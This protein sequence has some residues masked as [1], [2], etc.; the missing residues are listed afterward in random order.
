MPSI[1]FDPS[2]YPTVPISILAMPIV[3]QRE[4]CQL[5][6]PSHLSIVVLVVLVVSGTMPV[7]SQDSPQPIVTSLSSPSCDVGGDGSLYN[8]SIAST[9]FVTVAGLNFCSWASSQSPLGVCRLTVGNYS[10]SAVITQNSTLPDRSPLVFRLVSTLFSSLSWWSVNFTPLRR[11]VYPVMLAW[12]NVSY[13][14]TN[15]TALGI[16][17]L[18]SPAVMGLSGCGVDKTDPITGVTNTSGCINNGQFNVTAITSTPLNLTTIYMVCLYRTAS[19]AGPIA[20]IG[21]LPTTPFSF[22]F[23]L[24]FIPWSSFTTPSLFVI[25]DAPDAV[26]LLLAHSPQ[27]HL[28]YAPLVTPFFSSLVSGNCMPDVTMPISPGSTTSNSTALTACGIGA[29]YTVVGSG[30]EPGY[31]ITAGLVPQTC[32]YINSTAYRCSLLPSE[33][34]LGS[35]VPLHITVQRRNEEFFTTGLSVA[36]IGPLAVTCVTGCAQKANCSTQGCSPGDVV[37]VGGTGWARTL[38]CTAFSL[39]G[40]SSPL[41]GCVDYSTRL[42]RVV[43][44][45][46]YTLRYSPDQPYSLTMFLD[47]QSY[48]ADN[49]LS[50]DYPPNPV[51]WSVSGCPVQVGNRTSNCTLPSQDQPLVLTLQGQNLYYQSLFVYLGGIYCPGDYFYN[52]VHF[53]DQP[54]A[55]LRVKCYQAAFLTDTWLNL[56]L[57]LSDTPFDTLVVTQAVWFTAPS[58]NATTDVTTIMINSTNTD[59]LFLLFLLIIPVT[60]AM[61][62]F[63]FVR[64][65]QPY[66]T[67]ML[68]LTRL[69]SV[70]RATATDGRRESS[71]SPRQ[72]SFEMAPTASLPTSYQPPQAM[73]TDDAKAGDA[74]G[75]DDGDMGYESSRTQLDLGKEYDSS[76]LESVVSRMEPLM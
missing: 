68:L 74:E 1:T 45:S 27:A 53:S 76:S 5:F 42:I 25:V 30:L 60:V 58:T 57:T 56:A 32:Q 2:P 36:L 16:K 22:T 17:F 23:Q 69:R 12:S 15:S 6:K 47:S 66:R 20:M 21:I 34:Q 46:W 8:C 24:P 64:H 75:C 18:L 26:S 71:H 35:T 49:V 41:Q 29:N 33:S 48:T 62:A 63:V 67:A 43:L 31:V 11:D 28:S 4:G 3:C 50:F 70:Q 61:I 72:G 40:L 65:L 54:I 55:S 14:A 51:L 19:L 10:V 37:F 44:P 7:A 59:L 52:A 9:V 39:G 38:N 73:S 13:S